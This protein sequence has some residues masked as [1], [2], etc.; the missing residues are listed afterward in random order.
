MNPI[1]IALAFLIF[2]SLVAVGAF[3]LATATNRLRRPLRGLAAG[4]VVHLTPA[5]GLAIGVHLMLGLVGA[6]M[7]AAGLYA[8]YIVLLAR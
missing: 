1:G 3:L 7:T 8:T 4:P 6:V 5:D 2:W